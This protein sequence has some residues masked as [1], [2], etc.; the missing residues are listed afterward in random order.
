MRVYLDFFINILL[1]HT[2]IRNITLSQVFHKIEISLKSGKDRVSTSSLVI[3]R[4][5]LKKKPAKKY[6]STQGGGWGGFETEETIIFDGFLSFTPVFLFPLV[7][8]LLLHRFSLL[9]LVQLL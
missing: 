2:I 8:P 1:F 5:R 6:I 7:P 9:L 4:V 3:H